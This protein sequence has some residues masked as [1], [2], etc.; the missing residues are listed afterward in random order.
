MAADRGAEVA[1]VDAAKGLVEIAIQRTPQ[2]DLRVG[3]IE[4][5]PWQAGS[6][7]WVTGFNA[8]QFADDKA[9]ALSEAKRVSKG[10]VAIASPSR[11]EES[12]IARVFQQLFPLFPPEALEGMRQSG[13][14]ALSAPGKLED[15]LASVGLAISEDEEL[16]TPIVFDTAHT[17]VRA[18]VGAGPTAIAIQHSGEPAVA[19]VV[20]SAFT[21]FTNRDGQIVL[22]GWY[23]VVVARS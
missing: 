12:G 20:R 15:I 19:K 16:E 4:A 8:F 23:R 7:D 13:M 9:K 2:A 14:F 10:P 5:L 21:A 22:P 6:F 18:F 3:D 1:G 11:P 17:A